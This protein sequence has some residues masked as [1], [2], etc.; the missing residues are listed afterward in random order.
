MD[1]ILLKQELSRD[2]GVR[3][4]IYMDSLGIPS[5]GIGHNLRNGPI[6]QHVIDDI[7][8]EDKD[9]AI[10]ELD[11]QLPWWRTLSDARQRVLVNMTFNMGIDGVLEFHNTLAAL[12][13]GDWETAA[14]Q[15]ARSK[16]AKQ[17][18]A[19]AD[20]LEAMVRSG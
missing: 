13:S 1:E 2:E 8:E 10:K 6:S 18:G 5:I 15:M 20:R 16:W 11:D 12:Q 17:V 7:Y 9:N 19:R 4:H 14:K 3:P